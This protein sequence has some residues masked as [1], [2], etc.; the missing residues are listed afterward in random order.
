VTGGNRTRLENDR[1]NGGIP[2]NG[3]FFLLRLHRLP[4]TNGGFENKAPRLF[5]SPVGLALNVEKTKDSSSFAATDTTILAGSSL[6]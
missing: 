3:K 1:N 2:V 6:T 4:Q 5:P